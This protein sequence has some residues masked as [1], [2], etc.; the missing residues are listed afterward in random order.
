[1]MRGCKSSVVLFAYFANLFSPSAIAL[2]LSASP[3][4]RVT[5]LGLHQHGDRNSS[6]LD[7]A[8]PRAH[9]IVISV[10]SRPESEE[11]MRRLGPDL[12]AMGFSFEV[13]AGPNMEKYCPADVKDFE[14]SKA[15]GLR[16][17]GQ[18]WQGWTPDLAG[19]DLQLFQIATYVGHLR[20]W[21][22]IVDTKTP[23]VILEDDAEILSGDSMQ[24][25]LDEAVQAGADAVLLDP[26]H[27]ERGSPPHLAPDVSG[28]TA[29]WVDPKAAQAFLDHFNVSIPVDWA[30]NSVMNEKLQ[31]IC[32]EFFHVQEYGG[33]ELARI[34]S[35]AKGCM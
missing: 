23:A 17:L 28:L 31:A 7:A 27:C 14:Q 5:L 32:P 3:A 19:Y 22:R 25:T 9:V 20:A 15:A 4:T 1:M 18:E 33:E 16:L 24:G 12:E 35:A 10:P 8:G 21:Q 6:F 29:Y 13:V 34:H 30:V 2:R 11:R 26:R